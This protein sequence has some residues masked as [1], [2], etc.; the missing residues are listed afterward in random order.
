VEPSRL[1][2]DGAAYGGAYGRETGEAR[3]AA[4]LLRAAGG[5]ALEGTYSAKAFGVALA[6]TRR[7]PD[8]RVLFWLTFDGRWMAGGDDAPLA[9]R[10][11]RSPRPR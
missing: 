1:E 3:E 10:P 2:V 5:P 4:A 11:D 8:E 9:A 7:A 6:R